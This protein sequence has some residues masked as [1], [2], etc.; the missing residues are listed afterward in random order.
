MKTK[1]FKYIT[2]EAALRPVLLLVEESRGHSTMDS[3]MTSPAKHF[4]LFIAMQEWRPCQVS[5]KIT[6]PFKSKENST[7]IES[8][9]VFKIDYFHLPK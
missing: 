4:A 5:I 6:S 3:G 8:W 9:H 2:S 1:G 7:D